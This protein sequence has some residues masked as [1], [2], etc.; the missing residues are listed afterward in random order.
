MS[1]VEVVLSG[2]THGARAGAR[3]RA[4]MRPLRYSVIGSDYGAPVFDVF[5]V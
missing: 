5:E 1:A 3:E 4:G 2:H